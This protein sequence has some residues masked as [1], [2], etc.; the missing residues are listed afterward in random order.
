MLPSKKQFR[1]I[2]FVVSPQPQ[3]SI[4]KKEKRKTVNLYTHRPGVISTKYKKTA[5]AFDCI[6]V[7]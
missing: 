1:I 4:Y 6:H 5:H 7:V 3:R 2:I